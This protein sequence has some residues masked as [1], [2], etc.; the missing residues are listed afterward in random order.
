M[1]SLFLTAA[2]KKLLMANYPVEADV[3]RPLVPA[4][5]ELDTWHGDSL[6]PVVGEGVGRAVAA[7]VGQ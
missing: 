2:W 3:L 4:R 5:T 1:P 7:A 6:E